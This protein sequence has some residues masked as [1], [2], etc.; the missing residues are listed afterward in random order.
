MTIGYFGA[1]LF[2]GL[3][4]RPA[5]CSMEAGCAEAE[6]RHGRRFGYCDLIEGSALR[7][8]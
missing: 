2:A 6:A 3:S 5:G 4:A 7:A 1:L 8:A